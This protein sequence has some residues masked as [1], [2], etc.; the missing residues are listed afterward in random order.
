MEIVIGADHKGFELKQ[1]LAAWL[2]EMGHSVVDLGAH[3]LVDDD[4]YPD[5]AISVS[6]HVAEKPQ[7]R[8]GVLVCG[9]GV[10]V[11]VTANK[12]KGIRA[13]L[14]HDPDIARAAMRDDDIN[15]LALGAQYIAPNK[16]KE[17]VKAWLET[18]FSQEDRHK[19]RLE[20]ITNYESE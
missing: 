15:V 11:A 20:K 9:S 3:E 1:E 17:V 13:A 12:T 5:F 10:G 4:D 14:I 19:R 16:A 2:K 6:E 18:P 8:R 7:E